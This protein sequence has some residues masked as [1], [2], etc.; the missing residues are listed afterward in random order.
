MKDVGWDGGCGGR[1]MKDVGWDGGYG[2]RRMEDVG[3]EDVEKEDGAWRM[4]GC[5]M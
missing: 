4:W 1:R 5:K 3:M 2:G